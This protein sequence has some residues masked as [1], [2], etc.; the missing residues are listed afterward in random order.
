M[1]NRRALLFSL[2]FG[3][4]AVLLLALYVS[5][6]E[7][8]FKKKFEDVRVI[9]ATKDIMR[10]QH[11][12][13]SMLAIKRIPKPYVQPSA[14]LAE[15]ADR[16]IGYD[17]AD[18]TIKEGEQLLHTKLIPIGEGGISPEIQSG[19]R[20]CTIAINEVSGVAGLIRTSDTVD[21]IGTFKTLDGKTRSATDLEAVTL[22]QNITVLAVGRNYIM[23]RV[24]GS[25][26]NKKNLLSSVANQ[27]NF[28]NITLLV[29]P[30]QCMDLAIAQKAGEL[31]LALR[32]Y[33][34]RFTAQEIKQLKEI[35]STT[36]SVTG[37]KEP[38]EISKQPRWMEMRGSESIMVP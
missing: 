19:Y 14:V 4:S 10:Y 8:H 3:G 2:L 23:D 6:I 33:Q 31:T 29:T 16:V 37:I 38:I 25:S 28:S 18:S 34:D 21:I 27:T 32:S 20:A 36:Q 26:T 15:E 1:K 22:F 35:R 17:M 5:N 24:P 11:L 9:I 7:D 12:D 30:R 13:K